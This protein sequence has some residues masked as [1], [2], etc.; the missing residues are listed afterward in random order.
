MSGDLYEMALT[1]PWCITD[2]ALEAMLSIAAR[3]PLPEGEIARRMH[4]PKTLALRT[5]PRHEDSRTMR[6]RDGVATIPI[7]GPIYRYADLFTRMSGGVTTDA[8]AR[9]LGTALDDPAISAILLMIDSPGGEATGINELADTIYQ[10][11][12]QK[13]IVAYIEGYGASAAYWI[14]SAADLV[15]ADDTALIGSIG[16][17]MG[18]PDPAKRISRTIDFVS[19]QS[20]KKRA[21]PTSDDGRTYLQSLVDD[22]TDVFVAK[23]ARNRGIDAAAV[24][25][26]AGGML[27][28][29]KAVDAGLA[30]MLGSEE[31]VHAA[32]AL[33]ALP[34][35]RSIATPTHQEVVSMPSE[36]KG[37]WAWVAGEPATA[38]APEAP[39]AP[40]PNSAPALQLSTQP[41]APAQPTPDPQL[42]QLRAEI[43]RLR[44]EQI[45]KD[46][47]AF[48]AAELAANRAYPA[49]QAALA[50]LYAQ[51]AADDA[52]NPITA[53]A[54]AAQRPLARVDLLKAA[55]TARPAHTLSKPALASVPPGAAVLTNPAG[56]P[57][58]EAAA[59]DQAEAS[60][61]AYAARANGNGKAKS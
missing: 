50:A 57:A 40:V 61:R 36:K 34:T 32:L 45:T 7:D 42:A 54:T 19:T 14:A 33:G 27:I 52:A 5:G 47:A 1:V 37:F 39:A 16:T 44:G 56:A 41:A 25:A 58:D 28:G 10:A 24:L 21:D 22:M 4:G 59:L 43:T 51:L 35:R 17:V 18:V 9:D 6:M 26:V 30:D 48:A 8:L 20:P 29:Q 11:R 53:D 15:V 49:E 13:P 2:E 23:V 12:G 3:D 55:Y 46:A 60:A 31:T 38:A